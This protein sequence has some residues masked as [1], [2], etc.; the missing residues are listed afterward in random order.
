VDAILIPATHF[1]A[2]S[3]EE[4]EATLAIGC[5]PAP[6]CLKP[7][8]KGGDD[9]GGELLGIFRSGLR[10]GGDVLHSLNNAWR[11]EDGFEL[12]ILG[13]ISRNEFF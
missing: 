7:A 9:E 11:M 10:I 4:G 2:F 12:R 13:G 3:L 5:V 1:L 6:E 8:N